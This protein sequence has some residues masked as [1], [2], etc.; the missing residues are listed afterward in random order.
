VTE[1]DS[2]DLTP[3]QEAALKWLREFVEAGDGGVVWNHGSEIRLLLD[4]L[5]QRILILTQRLENL[6]EAIFQIELWCEAYPEDI[7]RPVD[8]DTIKIAGT[9]L[10]AGGIEMGTLHAQW[11]RH[12]LGGISKIA[13]SARVRSE[14]EQGEDDEPFI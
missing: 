11:A 6:E 14:H 12:L 3:R 2:P 10:K 4:S 9:L 1:E 8:D 7:F 13:H 5:A